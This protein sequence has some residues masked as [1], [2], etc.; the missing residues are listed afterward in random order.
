MGVKG[1]DLVRE[2]QYPTK[3]DKQKETT[4][5]SKAKAVAASHELLDAPRVKEF[6]E[7]GAISKGNQS[8]L[9]E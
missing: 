4:D 9:A 2:T 1:I 8:Q 6:P 3:T 5:M 7:G